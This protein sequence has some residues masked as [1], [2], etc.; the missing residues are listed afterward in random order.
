MSNVGGAEAR[1]YD[2]YEYFPTK[3][4]LSLAPN[5]TREI[6]G[7]W[8]RHLAS[9]TTTTAGWFW[10]KAFHAVNVAELPAQVGV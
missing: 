10:C 2:I 4:T 3:N 9:F 6:Y 7:G 1:I 8:T 5:L